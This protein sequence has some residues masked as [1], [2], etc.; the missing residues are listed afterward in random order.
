VYRNPYYSRRADAPEHAREYAGLL[1]HLKGGD[2]LETLEEWKSH[3]SQLHVGRDEYL[4]RNTYMSW[5]WEYA[6]LP[7]SKVQVKRWLKEN[8]VQLIT[9]AEMHSQVSGKLNIL[10][11]SVIPGEMSFRSRAVLK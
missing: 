11:L 5:G 4:S 2:G 1:Y 10:C 9:K 7:P 6:A 8:P 3:E